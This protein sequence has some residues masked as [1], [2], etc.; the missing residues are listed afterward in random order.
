V[1]ISSKIMVAVH[2]RYGEE[3]S[4]LGGR[5]GDL[6]RLATGPADRLRIAVVAAEMDGPDAGIDRLDKVQAELD[7]LRSDAQGDELAVIDELTDDARAMRVILAGG[8]ADALAEDERAGLV[9]RHGWF[10]RLALTMGKNADAADRSAVVDAGMRLL[11]A[12]AG[13]GLFVLA[14]FLVGVVLMIVAIVRMSTGRVAWRFRPPAPGGSVYLESFAVFVGAF[15]VLQGVL[16]GVQSL[17]SEA[18]AMRVSL[19]A[20]WV[21]VLCPLWPMVRGVSLARIR[22]DLGLERGRGIA[23][24]MLA[25]VAGYLAGLPL[26]VLVWI[27]TILVFSLMHKS[28]GGG[29]ANPVAEAIERG[30]MVTIV[31]LFVLAT[32]WAPLVEESI[33]RGGLFRHMR[34]RFGLVVAALLVGVF[35]SFMHGYGVLMTPPLIMLS[36]TFSVM[37]EWRGSLI[38]PMTAHFLHNFVSLGVFLVVYSMAG[39]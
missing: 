28:Q 17:T 9:D 11:I 5:L 39:S 32:V 37:R 3:L 24:E 27:V 8:G 6:D 16:V 20:Q 14:A 19:I 10:A 23:R 31:L 4:A 12:L 15:L 34:S 21:L 30:D 36:V 1:T 38:A 29:P 7:S 26:F 2:E 13:F 33:F 25:G 35:F 18:T 22:A